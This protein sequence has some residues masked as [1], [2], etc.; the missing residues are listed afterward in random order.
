MQVVQGSQ[1]HL[2]PADR[3]KRAL[4]YSTLEGMV[5]GAF[6]AFGDHFLIAFAVALGSDSLQIGLLASVPGF[7]ASLVQLLDAALVRRMKSRKAVILTFALAQGLMFLPIMALGFFHIE[8]K[9]WWL[10]LLTTGYSVFGS[11]V[12]PAWGSIMSEVVPE[13]LRGRYFSMRGRL[14]TLALVV[15]FLAA[16]VFLNFLAGRA[17]WGF[18][19]LFGTAVVMRMASSLLLTQL[20]EAPQDQS[21]QQTRSPIADQKAISVA[22]LGRYLAFLF[23]MTFAVNIASPYFAVYQL[24]ELKMSYLTFAALDTVSSVAMILAITH[25]GNAADKVGNRKMLAWASL[26]IPL[27]PLLWLVSPNVY[28]LG[29]VQ[30]FSGVAWAGFSLC[31]LNYLF[32]ATVPTNRTRYLG[33]FNAGSGLAAGLGALVGGYVAPHLPALQGSHILTLFLVSGLLRGLVTLVFGPGLK[34]VRRVSGLSGAELFHLLIG[35]RPVT[36]HAGHRRHFHIHHH[37]A[38]AGHG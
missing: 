13:R 12:S 10:I 14:S 8:G 17:L 31:S 25:W 21:I 4:R 34:E 28:Y 19:L 22:T 6:L 38:P 36:R 1:S 11:L 3:V 5:Y 9:A 15:A 37:Q 24:R 23:A 18:G 20:Y 7:L 29:V 35:G 32:D 27:I 26:M 16:G 33:Y 2:P 30:A